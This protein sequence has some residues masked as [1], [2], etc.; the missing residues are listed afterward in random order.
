MYKNK[1][2]GEALWCKKPKESRKEV[3]NGRYC[4]NLMLKKK[5]SITFLNLD[6]EISL[7]LWSSISQVIREARTG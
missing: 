3:R 2:W 6:L 1:K 7:M 5:T 4:F